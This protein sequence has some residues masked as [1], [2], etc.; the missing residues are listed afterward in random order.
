MKKISKNYAKSVFQRIINQYKSNNNSE[1]LKEKLNSFFEELSL[2]S[3]S[4][5][6]SKKI[7]TFFHNPFILEQKKY[8]ILITLFP[9][10]SAETHSLLKM[11]LEKRELYLLN[12]IFS[13]F[14]ELIEKFSK[15]RKVKLITASYL[16]KSIGLILLQKLKKATKSKEIILE[17]EY[18]KEILGGLILESSSSSLDVSLLGEFKNLLKEA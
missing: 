15:I 8:E 13:D 5:K 1:Q 7:N 11:L 10:L 6:G 12:D 17:V 2:L 4:I 9:K 18:K 14:Q 3:A 16:D